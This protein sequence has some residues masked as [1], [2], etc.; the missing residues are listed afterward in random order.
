MSK[1]SNA[2]IALALGLLCMLTAACGGSSESG[3]PT[4]PTSVASV[5]VHGVQVQPSGTGVQFFTAFQFTAQ[6]TFPSGTQFTWNFGDGTSSVS[7]QPQA[8]H[9]YGSPGNYTVSVQATAG[10]NSAVGSSQVSVGS[11]VGQ[12]VGTMS[13]HTTLPTIRPRPISSF[14]LRIDSIQSTSNNRYTMR[15]SW[16]DNAGCRH[17]LLAIFTPPGGV[18]ANRNVAFSLEQFECNGEGG[19]ADLSFSGTANETLS[20]VLG[21]HPNPAI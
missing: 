17:S 12:W 19:Y 3:T 7:T 11:L 8:S 9:P 20:I 5:A 13:G 2:A 21:E 4:S 14:D 6:G 1:S 16:S 10:A 15:G 18:A